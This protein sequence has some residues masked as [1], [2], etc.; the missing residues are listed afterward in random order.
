MEPGADPALHRVEPHFGE[1]YAASGRLGDGEAAVAD[2]RQFQAF[3]RCHEPAP[4][5][6]GEVSRRGCGGGSTEM[7]RQSLGEMLPEH[8]D[9]SFGAIL[10]EH[11]LDVGFRDL[12]E[13]VEEEPRP[14]IGVP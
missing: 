6:A 1:G 7:L 11:L 8:G 12:W 13:P 4:R 14:R 9:R 3:H 10:E 2:H 5:L